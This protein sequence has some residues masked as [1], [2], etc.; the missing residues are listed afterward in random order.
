[1]RPSNHPMP[2]TIGCGNKTVPAGS[3]KQRRAYFHP[4]LTG[5]SGNDILV[6]GPPVCVPVCID[7]RGV[8]V[9]TLYHCLRQDRWWHRW[10][11][12][13]TRRVRIVTAPNQTGSSTLR[14]TPLCT[15]ATAI[16]R[17]RW[18][19]SSRSTMVNIPACTV[20]VNRSSALRAFSSA[21][22]AVQARRA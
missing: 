4:G 22:T 16:L 1:M 12:Y 20:I 13:R 18:K 19:F 7:A 8:V 21:R 5:T 10:Q 6:L 3:T 11:R 14:P 15:T 17:M 2:G 9:V